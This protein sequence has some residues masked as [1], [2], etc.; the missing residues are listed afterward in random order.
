MT[1][2]RIRWISLAFVI[3]TSGCART[4]MTSAPAPEIVGRTL[5]TIL[6]IADLADS[7]LSRDAELRFVAAS[8]SD[9]TRFGASRTIFV[10]GRQYN[11]AELASILRQNQVDGTLVISRGEAGTITNY[12]P[13]TYGVVPCAVWTTEFGCQELPMTTPGVSASS[14]WAKF[15][16]RVYDANTGKAMWSASSITEGTSYART[17]TM[18]RS[19]ADKTIERLAHDGIIQ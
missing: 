3:F 19:M 11:K 13:P 8:R 15:T 10:P 12:L 17:R 4:S 6:V 9:H 1:A 5:R 2:H 7:A 18:V 16:A 14:S